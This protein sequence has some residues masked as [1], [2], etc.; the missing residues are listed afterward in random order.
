MCDACIRDVPEPQHAAS[1]YATC[2][3]HDRLWR[4][5]KSEAQ[6]AFFSRVLPGFGVQNKNV[7]KAD[8]MAAMKQKVQVH[9]GNEL[10]AVAA[11]WNESCRSLRPD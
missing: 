7:R 6:L 9:H 8:A 1:L 10:R 2:A 11:S 3:F 4:D 5:G